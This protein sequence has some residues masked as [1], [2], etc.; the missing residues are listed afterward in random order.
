NDALPSHSF[1]GALGFNRLSILD[2]SERGHQPM[3][4]DAQT[5]ILGFNGEIYNA[6]SYKPELQAA[7]YNFRSRTDTE[8]ILRLYEHFRLDGMRESLKGMF[9]IVI[10]DLRYRQ[11]HLVR[12]NLGIKPFYWARQ[13]NTLFFGSEVKSF[14]VHPKFVTRLAENNLDEYF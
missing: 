12:D 10:V 5:V 3:C 13:G 9:A 8:V 7:G 14:Q 2:L 4:N 11:V 6:F 1:E